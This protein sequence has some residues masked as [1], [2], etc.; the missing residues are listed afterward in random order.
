M[1]NTIDTMAPEAILRG[2]I[3][4]TLTEFE[5]DNIT[6]VAQLRLNRLT[7]MQRLKLPNCTT[8]TGVCSL[9]YMGS[10]KIY[11]PKITSLGA[12]NG[13]TNQVM[14]FPGLASTAGDQLRY[15]ANSGGAGGGAKVLD[16]GPNVKTLASRC[17]YQGKVETIILRSSTLVAAASTNSFGIGAATDA[18][19]ACYGSTFYIPKVLYDELQTGTANDYYA[20]SNWSSAITRINLHFAQIEGSDYEHYYADGTPIPES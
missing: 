8:L 19:S 1:A 12:F 15:T 17:C 6:T 10:A 11:I 4:N 5:D 9:G 13:G 18:Q 2:I 16:L 7:N 3:S 20:A 14:V